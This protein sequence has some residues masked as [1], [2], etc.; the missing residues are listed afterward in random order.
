MLCGDFVQ[1]RHAGAVANTALLNHL[2][3]QSRREVAS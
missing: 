1:T 2:L 3:A